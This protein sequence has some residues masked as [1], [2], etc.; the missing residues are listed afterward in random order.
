MAGGHRQPQMERGSRWTIYVFY[1]GLLILL[2]ALAVY[3]YLGTFTRY[4]ADDYC[5]AAALKNYGFL[6]AQTYWWENWSG[7]YSFSFMISLV[8][9]LGV[10]IVPILPAL[11]TGLW[12]SSIIWASLP[13]LKNLQ[14]AHSL[15]ASTFIASSV[16]WITYRS[17]DDY[18]QIVFWQTGI[19]T[20]PV[21]LILFLL[22][23][24]IAIRRTNS[25]VKINWLELT[26]WFVFAF[27]GGGFSETGVFVQV[28]LLAACLT[29]VWLLKIGQREILTPILISALCGSILS[30]LVISLSP[31]NQVRSGGFQNLPFLNQTLPASLAETLSFIPEFI[32]GHT[33]FFIFGLFAG[34]FV[35]YFGVQEEIRTQNITIARNLVLSLVFVEIGIWAAI[36]PAYLLRGGM[37]PERVLLF[38]YFLIACLVVYWGSLCALFLMSNLPHATIVFQRWTALGLLVLLIVL[39]VFPHIVSQLQLIPPLQEY[40]T[41]WDERHQSLVSASQ[42]GEAVPEVKDVTRIV[43]LRKLRMKLWLTGDFETEPNHWINR[44]AAQYYGVEQIIAK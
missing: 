35:V 10:G 12:L 9:L 43:S 36:A 37:P 1:A 24:G 8:E 2:A 28:V 4:M 5:S 29:L 23:T 34:A 42:A 21:S 18:P 14:I 39:G 19:L 22:G 40:S 27:L 17:V 30:L 7:R 11:V 41:F 31:G 20:Y 33:T 6:G 13:V 38:A 16:L 32:R 3:A 15:A 25:P 44:C 26:G